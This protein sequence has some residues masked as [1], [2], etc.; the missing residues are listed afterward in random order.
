[1]SFLSYFCYAFMCICL[2]MPYGHLL[3]KGW[4]LISRLLCLIVNYVPKKISFGSKECTI[5]LKLECA[6]LG[7][8]L[9]SFAN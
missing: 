1:M 3:G 5:E 7:A 6:F 8:R 2:L 9:A 4:P